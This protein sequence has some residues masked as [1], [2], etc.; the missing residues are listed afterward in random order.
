MM[1]F[2]HSSEENHSASS[3]TPLISIGF[4]VLAVLM[5]PVF[6]YSVGP[7]GP[8]K[9]GDV[10][11]ATDRYRVPVSDADIAGEVGRP[12]TCILE[13]RTQLVVQKTGV[14]PQGSMIAEPIAIEQS[15]PHYCSTRI[16][17]VVHAH[18]VTLQADLWGGLRDMFSHVFSGR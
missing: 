9:V 13:S 15:D 6:L 10:V 17:V 14:S 18:Q 16:P 2:E 4:A 5:V 12:A 7:G 11:F 1:N 8:I 3:R